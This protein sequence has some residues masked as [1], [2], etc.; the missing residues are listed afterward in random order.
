MRLLARNAAIAAA[1][2]VIVYLIPAQG[3]AEVLVEGSAESMRL[4]A[5]NA[6]LTQV[7]ASIKSAFGI[8]Y[9]VPA[10][11]D[12]PISGSFEGSLEYVVS[13]VLDDYDYVVKRSPD[14]M[15]IV[16]VSQRRRGENVA[17]GESNMAPP[18]RTISPPRAAR[19]KPP[20][21]NPR[22]SLAEQN[23]AAMI[24]RRAAQQQQERLRARQ[25]PPGMPPRGGL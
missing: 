7:L 25:Q 19:P 17:G 8:R 11:L 20:T 2:G 18:A 9:R 21:P 1:V 23:E 22:A 15:E 5:T 6:P 10:S 14:T 16:L 12:Q 24:R 4:E 13:R 3:R